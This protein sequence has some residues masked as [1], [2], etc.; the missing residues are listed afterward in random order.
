M[1]LRGQD[2]HWNEEKD[3]KTPH[4]PEDMAG[5]LISKVLEKYQ[6]ERGF[7]PKIKF[8]KEFKIS[9]RQNKMDLNKP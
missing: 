5:D 4:L 8:Y 7:A 3:G 6:R 2:F 1:I 9:T